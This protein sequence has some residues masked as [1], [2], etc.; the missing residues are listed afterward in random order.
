MVSQYYCKMIGTYHQEYFS[1]QQTYA[2]L[3]GMCL[4]LDHYV[5]IYYKFNFLLSAVWMYQCM[6]IILN[7]G[8]HIAEDNSLKELDF[9]EMLLHVYIE[10][11]I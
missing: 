6:K 4:L 9:S 2:S 7:T 10:M 1:Q 3:L 11:L 5:I 8:I